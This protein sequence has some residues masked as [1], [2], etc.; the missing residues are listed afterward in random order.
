MQLSS[1][2]LVSC[3]GDNTIKIFKINNVKYEI[4]QTLQYHTDSVYKIIEL[5]NKNLVS[6]SKDSSILFYYKDNL[7]YKNNYKISTNGTCYTII[8]IKE[9]EIC[10]SEEYNNTICFYNLLEKKIISS[11]SNISKYN[12]EREWFIM[13]R[14]DLL[15]IPGENKISIINVNQYKL[16]RVIEVPGSSWIC[17]VCILIK[18]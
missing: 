10:Y 4:L 12:G 15:L 11:L 5:K 17:G 6:C 8:E 2:E 3:S 7:E 16:I 18:I 1:G 14:K 9:N 13:I